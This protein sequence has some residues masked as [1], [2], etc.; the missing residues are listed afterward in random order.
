MKDI[1]E[2]CT[3]RVAYPKHFH[4]SSL[5]VLDEKLVWRN[6]HFDQSISLLESGDS[7]PRLQKS[8]PLQI[9]G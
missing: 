6:E 9:F 1:A 3:K 4:D 2:K 8:L 5:Q 7:T